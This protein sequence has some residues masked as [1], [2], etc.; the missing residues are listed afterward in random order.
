MPAKSKSTAARK[1]SARKGKKSTATKAAA[2]APVEVA[3]PEPVAEPVVAEPVPV[4]VETASSSTEA[5]TEPTLDMQFKD[6][7]E[8]IAGFR[9]LPPISW[10]MSSVSRRML[11][12]RFVNP[13]SATES[14]RVLIQMLPSVHQVDLP[15]QHLSLML[16]ASS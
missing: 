14:A 4:V 1:S 9:L 11:T 10:L 7:L 2:P 15:S 6:I 12:S 16:S 3:A 13:T 5:S 8:R